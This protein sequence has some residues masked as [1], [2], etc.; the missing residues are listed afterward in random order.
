MVALGLVRLIERHSDELTDGLVEKFFTSPRTRD[1]RK[2]PREELRGRCGE[3]LQHLSEWLLSKTSSDIERRY[4]EIGVRRA[5][6]GVSV[7]DYCWGIVLMKEHLWEFLQR[8]GFLKS[9]MEIYG[10][11]ELLRLLDQFFDRALCFAVEGYEDRPQWQG[12]DAMEPETQP[13]V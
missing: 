6:Q 10:E 5:E 12:A 7:S 2:V 9:P 13:H 1:L 8:Q 3:I 11:L 4:Y